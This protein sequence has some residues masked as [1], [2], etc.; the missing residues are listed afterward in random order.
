MWRCVHVFGSV[1]GHVCICV[2]LCRCRQ[3]CRFI[4]R[5][6]NWKHTP[7]L[8]KIRNYWRHNNR[9][10]RSLYSEAKHDCLHLFIA[11][12]YIRNLIYWS[13]YL[14][15]CSPSFDWLR[16]RSPMKQTKAYLLLAVRNCCLVAGCTDLRQLIHGNNSLPYTYPGIP[17]VYMGVSRGLTG[18]TPSK[19]I[20]YCD[21]CLKMYKNILPNSEIL[22]ENPQLS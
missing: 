6:Q 15:I 19:K 4:W 5:I 3:C 7:H 20:H 2:C 22:W 1:F 17:S 13:H 9:P 14:L 12:S 16:G 21:R 10:T 11:S 8:D 18:S